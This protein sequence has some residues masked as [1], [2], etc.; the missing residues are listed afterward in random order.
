MLEY[1]EAKNAFDRLVKQGADRGELQ[2]LLM[3][4]IIFGDVPKHRS[5]LPTRR[6]VNSVTAKM[7]SLVV[8][9][10]ELARFPGIFAAG[11][12]FPKM[13]FY[14]GIDI[15]FSPDRLCEILLRYAEIL[16]QASSRKRPKNAIAE[17]NRPL[18]RLAEYVKRVTGKKNYDDLATLLSASDNVAWDTTVLRQ[19]L[20]RKRRR[21]RTSV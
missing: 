4:R 12:S 9:I 14:Q 8:Q 5:W 15:S 13:T 2:R 11:E 10:R 3:L 7:R 16:D 17:R 1:P 20:Y 18:F 6:S 19:R 21:S